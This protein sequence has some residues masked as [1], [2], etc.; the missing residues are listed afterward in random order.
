MRILAVASVLLA[1][2]ATTVAGQV[3]RNVDRVVLVDATGVTV[4]DVLAIEG[5]AGATV[6]LEVDG[7]LAVVRVTRE[8]FIGTADTSIVFETSDCTGDAYISPNAIS[9]GPSLTAAA[10]GWPGSTLYLGNPDGPETTITRRSSR[11]WDSTE[12]NAESPAPADALLVVPVV[13]LADFYQPPFHLAAG[14]QPTSAATPSASSS[15]S[16]V[17]T[18][19]P[20]PSATP[21]AVVEAGCCGDCNA[22]GEVR[23]EELIRGVNHLL[24]G[25]EA[26]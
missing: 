13:D 17:L 23:V 25:C 7:Q 21:T 4:G 16:P 10:I 9:F 11:N 20:P 15:P 18:S 22:D 2:A 26:P 1:A 14:T 8:R 24:T 3:V 12:C 6:A 5:P 19:T